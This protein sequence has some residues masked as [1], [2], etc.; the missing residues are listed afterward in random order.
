MQI[1]FEYHDVKASSTLEETAKN[2]LEELGTKF[3]MVIR[4]DVFFKT[5]NT[6]SNNTG[7]ICNIRLS[8]PGPR[9]F[10]EASH[11]NFKDSILESINDLERQLRKVKEK[12]KNH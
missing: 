2:K 9:I 5:E 10:A 1:I 4:A 6:T 3:D 11:D 8:L 12:M 7:K